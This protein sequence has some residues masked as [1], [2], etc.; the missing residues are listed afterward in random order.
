MILSDKMVIKHMKRVLVIVSL[1]VISFA[2]MASIIHDGLA[3]N[4]GP[5][6]CGGQ[7][8][9]YTNVTSD[10][11]GYSGQHNRG[12]FSSPGRGDCFNEVS[13]PE[14]VWLFLAGLLVF[15]MLRGK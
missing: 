5:K 11:P 14:T 15:R 13:E 10:L 12:N 1:S 2:F 8:I 6:F 4:H 9:F 7:V 3:E